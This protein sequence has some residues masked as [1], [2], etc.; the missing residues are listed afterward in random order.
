VRV[1]WRV[2]LFLIAAAVFVWLGSFMVHGV[3]PGP[4]GWGRG[5]NRPAA[6][7][8]DRWPKFL[9]EFVLFGL[10]AMGGRWILRL[11]LTERARR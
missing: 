11:R 8:L 7:R 10:I 3:R 2:L 1:A 6:P 4:G 9:A 5:F